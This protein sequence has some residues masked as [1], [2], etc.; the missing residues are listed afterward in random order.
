LNVSLDFDG[1]YTEDPQLW[2]TLIDAAK[3]SGH[4]VYGVTMRYP[5]ECRGHVLIEEFA[6]RTKLITTSRK[7][8]KAFVQQL[9]IHIDVWIDDRPDFI[10]NDAQ[11]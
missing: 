9:G 5:A 1:T 8:K 11:I 10:F 4:T 6:L 3:L 7:A 2:N